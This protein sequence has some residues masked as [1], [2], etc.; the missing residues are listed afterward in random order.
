VVEVVHIPL[1]DISDA[2]QIKDDSTDEKVQVSCYRK[3]GSEWKQKAGHRSVEMRDTSVSRPAASCI[4]VMSESM[5]I[6]HRP[7]DQSMHRLAHQP[8]NPAPVNS[9]Y[10]ASL[11]KEDILSSH[12]TVLRFATEFTISSLPNG[13]GPV[14][15]NRGTT[16]RHQFV[17]LVFHLST[18]RFIHR[19]R[20]DRV[21]L[22][23]FESW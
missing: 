18:L 16:I 14:S 4:H 6:I 12:M 23:R 1:T 20:S 13:S 9:I 11:S 19:R 10:R 15:R 3:E 5:I 2:A 17:S 7:H 8:T 21:L 22:V